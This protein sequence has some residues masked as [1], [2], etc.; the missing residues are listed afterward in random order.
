MEHRQF[1]NFKQEDKLDHTDN[2]I[3]ILWIY[4][5]I[6]DQSQ[7]HNVVN[8]LQGDE[9]KPFALYFFPDDNFD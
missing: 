5:N 4:V 3:G 1:V 6:R 7:T 2:N 8:E 9:P